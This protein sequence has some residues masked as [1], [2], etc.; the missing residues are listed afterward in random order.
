MSWLERLRVIEELEDAPLD[1][2]LVARFE[3]AASDSPAWFAGR[4]PERKQR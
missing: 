4:E 2:Q 1:G 3:R